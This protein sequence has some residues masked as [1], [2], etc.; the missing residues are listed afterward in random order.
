MDDI[1]NDILNLCGKLDG[2]VI[3]SKMTRSDLLDHIREMELAD[4]IKTV[5]DLRSMIKTLGAEYG[6]KPETV[7][8]AIDIVSKE[9]KFSLRYLK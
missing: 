6:F 2:V 8:R 5:K 1:C 7:Q 9:Q 4:E 3:E